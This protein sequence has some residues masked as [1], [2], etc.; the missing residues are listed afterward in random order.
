[1]GQSAQKPAWAV[2]T[3]GLSGYDW[4]RANVLSARREDLGPSCL[5]L[6][7]EPGMASASWV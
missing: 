4:I 7:W 2:F 3:R 6:S 5:G 1:M